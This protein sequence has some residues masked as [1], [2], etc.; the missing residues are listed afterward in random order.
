VTVLT[1]QYKPL[2]INDFVG[3]EKPKRICSRLARDPFA[4]AYLFVGPSGTGKSTMAR[5]LASAMNAE[6]QYI[7]SQECNLPRIQQVV[8]NCYHMPMFGAQWWMVLI[9][10]ADAMS[11]AAQD[12]LLSTLDH[13]PLNTVFVFTCNDTSRFEARFLSRVSTVEFSSYGIAKEAASLLERVWR[14]NTDAPVPNV[15]RI[16]KDSSNNVRAA[17]MALQTELMMA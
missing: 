17:L 11:K 15:Q 9:D 7:P 16:V 6:I 1:E 2:Q 8:E 14:E 10:E 4:S 12:S 13:L 5:A 3:L